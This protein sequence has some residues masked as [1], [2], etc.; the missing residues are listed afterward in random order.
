MNVFI[1]KT[2]IRNRSWT[3]QKQKYEIQS[4]E[5]ILKLKTV[6]Q[7]ILFRKGGGELEILQK[8]EYNKQKKSNMK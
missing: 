5:Y 7:L 8:Q 3:K 6:N 2:N 4:I 1:S